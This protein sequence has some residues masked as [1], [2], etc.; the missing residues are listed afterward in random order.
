M[1]KYYSFDGPHNGL[2][3]PVSLQ[4]ML[5]SFDNIGNKDLIEWI[6][7]EAEDHAD[8]LNSPAWKELLINHHYNQ[9]GAWE[10]HDIF[11]EELEELGMPRN[12]KNSAITLGNTRENTLAFSTSAPVNSG[13]PAEAHARL[14]SVHQSPSKSGILVDCYAKALSDNPLGN[15]HKIAKARFEHRTVLELRFFGERIRL[16]KDIEIY[17]RNFDYFNRSAAD[18]QPGAYEF[19]QKSIADGYNSRKDGNLLY[20]PASNP[21]SRYTSTFIPAQS[22]LALTEP[23]R[24]QRFVDKSFSELLSEGISQFDEILYN[25]ESN[26]HWHQ[27]GFTGDIPIDLIEVLLA[28]LVDDLLG[29]KKLPTN[30]NQEFNFTQIHGPE[31]DHVTIEK[32]GVLYLNANKPSG[33]LVGDYPANGSKLNVDF[34]GGESEVCGVQSIRVATGGNLVLGD[35]VQDNAAN[36]TLPS[37]GV[38]EVESGG[39][40]TLYND[41]RIA[42]S[43]NARLILHR[44]AHV[45]LV[46]SETEVIIEGETSLIGDGQGVTIRG[47]GV[48]QAK[49]G[50]F[51]FGARNPLN[52]EGACQVVLGPETNLA[53][54]DAANVW[55]NGDQA[56][57][58]IQGRLTLANEAVWSNVSDGGTAGYYVLNPQ[59]ED[60]ITLEGISSVLFSGEGKHDRILEVKSDAVF[61]GGLGLSFSV[62][63]SYAGD[64]DME[65]TGLEATGMSSVHFQD[66]EIAF[67]PPVTTSILVVKSN[68]SAE[69]V[70]FVQ[71]TEGNGRSKFKI[72]GVQGYV[73][74]DFE[75]DGVMLWAESNGGTAVVYFMEGSLNDSSIETQGYAPQIQTMNLENK[76]TI[77]LDAIF[78][79]V[80]NIIEVDGDADAFVWLEG[81]GDAAISRCH[82]SNSLYPIQTRTTGMVSLACNE[83][84]NVEGAI[85]FKNSSLNMGMEYG[86][87]EIGCVGENNAPMI[88]GLEPL[89]NHGAI[90]AEDGGNL[91][92]NPSNMEFAFWNFN[93]VAEDCNNDIQN[94]N[95]WGASAF[96][97]TQSNSRFNTRIAC[98]NSN[99]IGRIVDPSPISFEKC[100]ALK[101]PNT[102][103]VLTAIK[104]NENLL[105]GIE[106]LGSISALNRLKRNMQE[107]DASQFLDLESTYLPLL[108]AERDKA[109][110]DALYTFKTFFAVVDFLLAVNKQSVLV[111]MLENQLCLWGVDAPK[112]ENVFDL[113]R[114]VKTQNHRSLGGFGT[115]HYS[116]E[117]GLRFP[118]C[119]STSREA[120]EET[121]PSNMVVYPNPSQHSFTIQSMGAAITKV[122]ICNMVS[123]EC[124]QISVPKLKSTQ[125]F[126]ADLAKGLYLLEVEMENGEIE[127]HKMLRK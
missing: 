50:E 124:H 86:R 51:S 44:G 24:E 85:E 115:L 7:G 90:H 36:L 9:S 84:E 108:V 48:F 106:G 87:N 97:G 39:T 73:V 95:Q 79:V 13:N 64:I 18:L 47:A 57:V 83:F 4:F 107:G 30:L 105:E 103:N 22:A 10:S 77:Q 126:G 20:A 80:T 91:F 125:V 12:T 62:L 104:S 88:L 116:E 111:R 112:Y 121:S 59:E 61:P 81:T 66:G 72:D 78:G 127:M 109:E 117:M 42:L 17:H 25:T 120:A 43:G 5:K 98:P 69:N 94:G 118:L 46:G 28:T 15:N 70:R 3:F 102:G 101:K 6:S 76:S 99:K 123:R 49:Q 38:L 14:F 55:L 40:V 34:Q 92:N 114:L 53:L 41:S 58:E 67:S 27:E 75:A 52:V 16:T 1:G 93:S 100:P 45:Q 113:I 31:I 11:Y 74:R 8:F 21:S 54:N 32:D 29:F 23:Y 71:T 2:N 110:S 19:F 37:D 65:T 96:S 26:N 122:R 63:D 119:R 33:F 89:N 60:F 82:F 68:G 35:A 56:R